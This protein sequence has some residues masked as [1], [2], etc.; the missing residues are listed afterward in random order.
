MNREPIRIAEE[1]R[2]AFTNAVSEAFAPIVEKL[3]QQVAEALAAD[4]RLTA[5]RKELATVTQP[6]VLELQARVA[7]S[8]RIPVQTYRIRLPD[9]VSDDLQEAFGRL[10]Q[11]ISATRDRSYSVPSEEG[12]HRLE[13]LVDS[14]E[15]PES[16]LA[17]VEARVAEDNE[18]RMAVDGAA[19]SLAA[20]R[21]WLTR[22]RARQVVVV[23]VWVIWSAGLV[24]L[25]LVPVVGAI[26]GAVGLDSKSASGVAGKTFDRAFP[27]QKDGEEEP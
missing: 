22:K 18:L 2:H 20:S 1:Q 23:W 17:S 9:A 6:Q 12:V 7:E 8:F 14:G 16:G 11:A 26:P 3:R 19:A 13:E 4:P 21:P 10:S 27:P 15:I 24:L 25:S 5:I